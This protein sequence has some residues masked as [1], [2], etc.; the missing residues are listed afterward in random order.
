NKSATAGA[1]AAAGSLLAIGFADG[2]IDLRDLA[3]GHLRR[4]IKAG[5]VR[6]D[7]LHVAS[8]GRYVAAI[9]DPCPGGEFG[10]WDATSGESMPEATNYVG[11]PATSFAFAHRRPLV[12]IGRHDDHSI[13]IWDLAQ[14]RELRRLR[15]HTWVV[16]TVTFSPDDTL[17]S[18]SSW[19]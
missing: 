8:D 14:N 1:L 17:L 15:D 3:D 5:K 18:S 11:G 2:T 9:L 6:V 16:N 7:K 19:D 10:L 12:A 13:T 4:A